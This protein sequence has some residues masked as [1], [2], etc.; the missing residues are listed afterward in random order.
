MKLRKFIKTTIREYLKEELNMNSGGIIA[1]HR[2]RKKFNKFNI[3]NISVD[4][5]RQRYG[6]GLYFSNS[7]PHNQYGEYLYKV[8][9]FKNKKDYVL[10]DTKNSVDDVIVNKIVEA[11]NSYNKKSDEV[12][13]FGYNGWL[14][15]KTISRILGGDKHASTFLSNNGVDGLKSNIAKNWYDYILFSDNYIT[16]K[17]IK[18]DPY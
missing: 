15:Y 16:I 14:F 3:S 7:I 9:L 17:D 12:V 10:I 1:Y 18:Y 5:N 2:S 6:Y 8:I 4:S 13:E 11:L